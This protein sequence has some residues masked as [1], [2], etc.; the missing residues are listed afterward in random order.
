MGFK[1]VDPSCL[2][3]PQLVVRGLSCLAVAIS[4]W[5]HLTPGPWQLSVAPGQDLAPTTS[6]GNVA[7]AHLTKTAILPSL[8]TGCFQSPGS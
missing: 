1:F 8:F 5:G 2:K 4:D 6:T 7:R 3:P